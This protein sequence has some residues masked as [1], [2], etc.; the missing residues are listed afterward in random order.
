M[1]TY[2][3]VIYMVLDF[4][5]LSSDD[6]YYTED[7]VKFLLNKYRAYVLQSR[8]GDNR[9]HADDTPS[10]SNYQTIDLHLQ[11]VNRVEGLSCS[12]RYLRSI[13]EIPTTLNY[14]NLHLWAGDMFSDNL[15][16]TMPA[17]FKYAGFGKLGSMFN[18]ATIGKDHH[19]YLKSGNPQMY[20]LEQVSLK[21]IFEDPEKVH[22]IL[23]AQAEENGGEY[24][25][26]L[27]QSFP[28]EDNLLALCM[29]YVVK[30]L[31]GGIYKPRDSEN[32]AAD[33][34]SELANFIRSYTKSPLQRQIYGQ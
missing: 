20:Y 11:Q 13:E 26:L 31:N 19:L 10:E 1:A 17:R 3:E 9:K 27:D 8:Y 22:E 23:A 12:G 21:G 30:E 6:S 5:K 15:I 16:F 32:N 7:H 34:L 18:Y 28:L 29:Q 24:P 33:D 25:C 4:L 2:R 14:S